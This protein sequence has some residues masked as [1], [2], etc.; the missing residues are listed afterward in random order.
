MNIIDINK[1]LCPYQFDIQLDNVTYTFRIRYNSE[2]DY[3]TTDLLIGEVEI[4]SGEKIVYGRE[5][6][7]A[8]NHLNIPRGIIA[9][10]VADEQS[11]AG[12]NEL[13]NT[14]FLYLAGDLDAL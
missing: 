13:G 7:S 5:L 6:F 2:F 11:R 8:H 3:F 12:Y 1:K 14:V 10:D 4:L 9:L